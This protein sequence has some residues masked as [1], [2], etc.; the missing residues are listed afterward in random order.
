[1]VFYGGYQGAT[2]PATNYLGLGLVVLLVAALMVWRRDR[3]LWFFAGLG[4]VAVVLSFGL[5]SHHWTPWRIFTHIPLLKNILPTRFQTVV[6]LCVATLLAIVVDRVHSSVRSH[7]GAI[8]RRWVTPGRAVLAGS[9]S[10]SLAGLAVAAA[11]LVPVGQEVAA[12]TP[13]TTQRVTVPQWFVEVAPHLPP[14]QVVLTYPAPF[15]GIQSSQTWQAVDG[16]HFAQAGGGGP[17]GIPSRAGKERAGFVVLTSASFGFPAVPTAT[18]Q[19]VEAVRSALRGWG[20]TVVVVPD[21]A[22]TPQYDR[23]VSTPSALGLFTAAIGRSPRYTHRA[24]TWTD[25]GSPGPPLTVSTEAF[26]RCTTDEVW[27]SDPQGVPNCLMAAAG[28]TT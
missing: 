24:W 6:I 28:S 10:A 9:L 7:A 14:G 20:V 18:P 8:A 4:T 15:S 25:V 2:L 27:R 3:R 16:M 19:N 5:N 1:L 12:S 26:Q 13:L 17:Q 11:V 22:G 21:P 23:G